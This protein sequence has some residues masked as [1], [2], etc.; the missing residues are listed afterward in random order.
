MKLAEVATFQ[1]DKF[2]SVSFPITW[3]VLQYILY[4]LTFPLYT[5]IISFL[6]FLLESVTKILLEWSLNPFSIVYTFTDAGWEW[7][8]FG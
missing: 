1:T 8:Q 6:Y 5:W 7:K 2:S 4:I 3:C